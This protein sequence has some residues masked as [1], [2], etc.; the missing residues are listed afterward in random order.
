VLHLSYRQATRLSSHLHSSAVSALRLCGD[1]NQGIVRTRCSAFSSD[2]FRPFSCK[3][4][5]LSS[6]CEQ[7]QTL[8]LDEYFDE[9]L[10]LTLPHRQFVFTLPKALR[11]F[12]RQDQRLFADLPLDVI[13]G[14]SASLWVIFGIS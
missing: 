9:Q 8:L 4:Y 14:S 1:W 7:K 5:L 12:L 13:W 6:S 10:L 11:V 3:S 2:R